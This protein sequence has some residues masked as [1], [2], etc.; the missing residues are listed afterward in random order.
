MV[1]LDIIKDMLEEIAVLG[2]G[3]TPSAEDADVCM[4]AI[5]S[6]LDAW[7]LEN[8]MVYDTTMV[9][10]AL[11]AATSSLAIGT[12]LALNT[13]RPV[14]LEEGCYITV[15]TLDFPLEIVDRPKYNDIV[16]KT[17]NGPWPTVCCYDADY[18]SGTV[19]FWPRGAC[20]VNLNVATV[21]PEFT[22]TS[23]TFALPPGYRRALA[24]TGAEEV[25]TKFERQLSPV[26]VAKAKAARRAIKRSNVSVPQ[27]DVAGQPD[28][29]PRQIFFG[30]P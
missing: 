4:R 27:L 29:G 25:A 21:I 15:G 7:R 13:T 24:L 12:G 22:L 6:V 3:E 30:L 17:L 16:L 23:A 10:A 19:L 26:T 1:L 9:S 28:F 2:A 8:L 18:P 20:T 11:P 5:N 14:R